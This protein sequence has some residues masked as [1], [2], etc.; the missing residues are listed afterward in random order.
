ML[1]KQ[2]WGGSQVGWRVLRKDPR[3]CWKDARALDRVGL[4]MPL[5]DCLGYAERLMLPLPFVAPPPLPHWASIYVSW[6]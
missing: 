3:L 1:R 5:L 2:E 6:T 4:Q